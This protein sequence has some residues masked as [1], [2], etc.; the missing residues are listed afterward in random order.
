MRNTFM[1]SI[2]IFWIVAPAF[3]WGP[4]GHRIVAELARQRLNPSARRAIV[5]LLGDDDLASISTWADEVRPSRPE[6]AG[7]HFVDIPSSATAFDEPRDC[8][9]PKQRVPATLAD[10]HNCVVD[11]ITMFER[12]LA[13]LQAPR[14]ERIEALKFLVHFVGDIHQP[15][16]A[17]SEARGGN[18]I[19]VVEFGHRECGHRECDLHG[20][21]DVGLIHHAR[22]N[23][24]LY[25]ARLSDLVAREGLDSKS[26]GTP[27]QWANDSFRLAHAV[28]VSEGSDI[29]ESYYRRNRPALDRQLALAGVRL[30]HVLNEALGK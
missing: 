14:A 28:W 3:A 21:W 4:E 8:Y 15:L 19:H 13:D 6:T 10:H 5:Q 27:A 22:L 12:V 1:R 26:G 30:A 20:T 29:D 18:D 16:H 25:T 7:W 9:H 11:R 24:G 23:E 17:I 2:V